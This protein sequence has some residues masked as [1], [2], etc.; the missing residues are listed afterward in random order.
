[1]V[2]LFRFEQ[3]G[4]LLD[5]TEAL[6][7]PQVQLGGKKK[8]YRYHSKIFLG[9]PDFK[10]TQYRLSSVLFKMVKARK[11]TSKRRSTKMAQ[12]LKK[13]AAAH[14]RKQRKLA[15]KDVTWKSRVEKDP[16]IPSAFPYKDRILSEMEE[17]KREEDE[18][19]ELRKQ[20][21]I[22]QQQAAKLAKHQEND[23]D[24]KAVE[25]TSSDNEGGSRL[26][27]LLESAQLAAEDVELSDEEDFEG[28][29]SEEEEIEVEIDD[30]EKNAPMFEAVYTHVIDNSDVVLYVLDA[31]EPEGSRAKIAEKY[32][33]EHPEKR[34]LFVLNKV[35]L[36]P[37]EVLKKWQDH[38]QT[39]FPTIPMISASSA[40][41][42]VTFSHVGVTP[43]STSSTL[44]SSLKNYAKSLERQ[45]TVGVLGYPNT[46][47]SSVV[48]AIIDRC[49]ANRRV[50]CQVAPQAGTTNTIRSMRVDSK[51]KIYDSPGI[52][53]APEKKKVDEHSR[54]VLLG[55][56]PPKHVGDPAPSVALLVKRLSKNA[57]FKERLIKYYSLPTLMSPGSDSM[58]HNFLVGVAR[59][60][61]RLGKS[62]VP[63]VAS[64]AMEV[65]NDWRDGRI[66]GWTVPK[67]SDV[68]PTKNE[69]KWEKEF[70]LSG[71]WRGEFGVK[72]N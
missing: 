38:L 56:L 27:A 8:F 17:R 29:D 39:F 51:L 59:S 49:N 33:M 47:K 10:P 34:F 19:K 20:H 31:R 40:A 11:P 9:L 28:S 21:R 72:S 52:C 61:G 45:I 6:A 58:V 43:L 3:R 60:K 66:S 24:N 57:V 64:A 44:V 67:S 25:S 4:L 12:G 63:D 55:A 71:L 37:T 35:D 46:G 7:L 2:A 42:A 15:K 22:E 41:H 18:L 68:A 53:F 5:A 14:Q 26:G 30:Y 13:K 70:K 65:I 16:G 32:A 69:K 48:N 54:L 62:G 36:I 50:G 1:M 23:S